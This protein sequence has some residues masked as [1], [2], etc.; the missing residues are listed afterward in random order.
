MK[1]LFC[2]YQNSKNPSNKYSVLLL[3]IKVDLVRHK[4]GLHLL[5]LSGLTNDLGA[6]VIPDDGDHSGLG[7]GVTMD[8]VPGAEGGA[9]GGGGA[10]LV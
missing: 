9:G 7:L 8:S 5:G 6:V 1:S 4:V 2:V 3:S 10:G